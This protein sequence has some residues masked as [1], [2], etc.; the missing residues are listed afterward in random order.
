MAIKRLVEISTVAIAQGKACIK[1]DDAFRARI[2]AHVKNGLQV[3]RRVIDVGEE[4]AQP[5][6]VGNASLL[7]SPQRAIS[8]GGCRDIGFYDAAQILVSRGERH[9]HHGFAFV[10]NGSQKIDVAQ[11]AIRLGKKRGSEAASVDNLQALPP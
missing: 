4:R 8:L 1:H 11:K 10:V 5:Y 2:E 6:N 3:L 9:L 7:E